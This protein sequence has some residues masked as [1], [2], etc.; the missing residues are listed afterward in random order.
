MTLT[1]SSRAQVCVGEQLELTCAT[2]ET[3]VAW[4]FVPHLINAQGVSIALDWFIS[5]NDQTQQ[6]QSFTV[7]STSF[8]FMRTSMQHS[9]PLV[10]MLIIVNSSG[11][12]DMITVR[13]TKIVDNERVMSALST[14]L[15][16]GATQK[17]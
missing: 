4:N 13:C 12:L 11:A 8:T 1:P 2:N 17:G 6:L 7:N 16:I 9:S 3:L 10:S 5:S 15:V 14:I